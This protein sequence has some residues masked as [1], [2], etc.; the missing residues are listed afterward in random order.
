MMSYI[1]IIEKY[2][3]NFG[4]V[5]SNEIKE[6]IIKIFNNDLNII[7]SDYYLDSDKLNIVGLYYKTIEKDYDQMKKYYLM[8]IELNNSNS[9]NNLA[10]YYLN[11]KLEFYKLLLTLKNKNESINNQIKLLENE[12]KIKI[13]KN[14]ILLFERLKNYKTC[15]LCLQDNTLNIDLNCGHEIC[16]ECYNDNLKCYFNWCNN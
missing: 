10:L 3:F 2:K 4:K 12:K 16:T 9:M 8:A 5:V 13:Y 1:E 15:L 6:F 14:K 11:N 7:E